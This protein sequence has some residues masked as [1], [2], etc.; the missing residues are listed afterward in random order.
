MCS[1]WEPVEWLA[2]ASLFYLYQEGIGLNSLATKGLD[3]L[4]PLCIADVIY[5][6]VH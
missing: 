6:I 4:D 5:N 2:S 1:A 3:S